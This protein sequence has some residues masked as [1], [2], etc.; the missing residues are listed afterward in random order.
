[1]LLVEDHA[2]TRAIM[3]FVL[4]DFGCRVSSACDVAEA[5]RIAAERTFDLVISDLGLPD[6]SGTDLMRLLKA[7]Y[8][9]KGIALSGY[10]MDSDR[11]RS[12]DAG[13]DAHLVKPVNLDLLE[14]TVRRLLD[15]EPGSKLM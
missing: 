8:G 9:L 6:G 1:V 10:G 2:D 15:Q 4:G 3:E 7:T 12:R 5:L 13:F 14:A 11:T